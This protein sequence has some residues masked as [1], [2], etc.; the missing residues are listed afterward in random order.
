MEPWKS[1]LFQR[2]PLLI[3]SH[4]S[5]QGDNEFLSAHV[6]KSLSISVG[7]A[8]AILRR[9]EGE[10]L[11]SSR[12]IGHS[13]FYRTV[14]PHPFWSAFRVFDNLA[15]VSPLV[16]ILAPL[17]REV[18]LFGSCSRG[19]DDMQSDIDLL[20]VTDS[21]GTKAAEEVTRAPIGGRPVN[22][23]VLDYHAYLDLQEKDPVFHGEIVKGLRLWEATDGRT[24]GSAALRA[25][26][27]GHNRG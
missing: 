18:V 8:H 19:E 23:V 6:A 13:L 10:G 9:F 25:L 20:V 17:S 21:V 12:R 15:A 26:E 11:I 7:S 1:F 4:I 16:G 24:G 22:A 2:N 14:R 27:E 5:M 3:L